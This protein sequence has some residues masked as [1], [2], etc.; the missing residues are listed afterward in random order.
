MIHPPA[1]LHHAVQQ[2]FH[3]FLPLIHLR[4]A[5]EFIGLMRLCNVAWATDTGGIS[6]LLK[7][8]CFGA[9]ADHMCAIVAR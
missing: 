5:D 8:T 9:I 3:E 4:D 1:A 6:C 7:L 2:T